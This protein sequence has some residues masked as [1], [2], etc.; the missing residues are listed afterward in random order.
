MANWAVVLLRH[1][2]SCT[3]IPSSR[4]CYLKWCTADGECVKGRHEG[5]ESLLRRGGGRDS[6]LQLWQK[7]S[8]RVMPCRFHSNDIIGQVYLLWCPCPHPLCPSPYRFWVPSSAS[9]QADGDS[10]RARSWR[11][12]QVRGLVCVRAC[13]HMYMH[14][15]CVGHVSLHVLH[16]LHTFGVCVHVLCWVHLSST[17]SSA[18]SAEWLPFTSHYAHFL[19]LLQCGNNELQPVSTELMVAWN[20]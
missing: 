11:A 3:H 19:I 4:F 12:N 20:V 14:S 1:F 18:V 15:M 17:H 5:L 6:L 7:N 9:I 10:G 2:G 8:L 13:V 16:V